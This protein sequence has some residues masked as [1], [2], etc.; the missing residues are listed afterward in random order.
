MATEIVD[1]FVSHKRKLGLPVPNKLR[2]AT[3]KK[4]KKRSLL[5]LALGLDPGRELWGM[6]PLD[7]KLWGRR[8]P[9]FREAVS[10]H[11]HEHHARAYEPMPW[12]AVPRSRNLWG[13]IQVGHYYS[14]PY[15]SHKS[16]HVTLPIAMSPAGRTSPRNERAFSRPHFRRCGFQ[17]WWRHQERYLFMRRSCRI[18]RPPQRRVR[19]QRCI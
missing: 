7:L 10:H 1:G 4:R 5:L 6:K 18:R 3:L 12:Y 14:K 13:D 17:N 19:I 8:D 9:W 16:H 2:E 11:H 15:Y